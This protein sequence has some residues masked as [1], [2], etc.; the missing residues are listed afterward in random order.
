LKPLEIATKVKSLLFENTK[1]S[2]MKV[3][4]TIPR[5]GLKSEPW[6][7][8][9]C[10][11]KK[12]KLRS[13]ANKVNKTPNDAEVRNMLSE[14][15]RD[16]KRIIAIKK[17]QHKQKAVSEL[18]DKK[19]EG[20]PK[21]FWKLFRKISPK[22][23][24]NPIMPDISKFSEHFKKI[25]NSARPLNIPPVCNDAGPLDYIIT[26]E[27]LSEATD[28]LKLGKAFG[29]DI[30]CNEMIISLV[31]THPKI[32]LKLFNSTLSSNEVI[33]DWVIGMIVPLYKD[34]SKMDANNYR[35][36]TLISCLGKLFLS[37]LN[38]RLTVFATDNNLLTKSALGFV[39]GNRTSDAHIII[40]NLVNKVCHQDRSHIYSCFVDFKKAFD[41]V[42]RDILLKKLL[43]AG[44]SGKFFNIIRYIYTTDKACIKLGNTQSDFFQLS[45]G[46]RQGCILSPLLFN[47]FLSD[48][49]RKFESMEN[50]FQVG[51]I[52]INSLFWADDLVLFAK[53][54]EDLDNLLK[55][56]ETYC[57]EN[58]ITINT[59]KTKCMIFNKGGRLMRRQFY[60]DG[61]QLENVRSYKYLGFLITP[62]GE[63]NTGF[64]DLR[65]RALKAFMKIKN[66]MGMS[67]NQNLGTTLSLIDALIKPILLYCGDFWGCLKLPRNNHIE[68]MHMMICKRL[69]GVQK[70]TTNVGVLLEL[71]RIPLH[72]YASK[73]AVKN[74]ERIRLGIGNEILL[75][76]CRNSLDNFGWLHNIKRTLETNKMVDFYEDVP[77]SVYPFIHKKLFDK[78]KDKFHQ[79]SFDQI[80]LD[81]S[82]LRTYAI[83]KSEVG[84]EDYLYEIKNVTDRV[85]VTKFRLSNH[86]LMIEVGRHNN[87]PKELRYCPFCPNIVENE[88][89]FMFTC[90]SYTHLR[91][92]YLEPVCNSIP[93]FQYLPHDA[94]L[95][96]LLSS[97][98]KGTCKFIAS[99]MDLRRFLTSRPKNTD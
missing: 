45:L 10:K 42:P 94:K 64:K 93:S 95:Q 99:S 96:A 29:L 61:V 38:S 87:T 16:F 31:K 72:L 90:P 73:F 4:K 88:K 62:S 70:Q 27:E 80:K 74:W 78:L 56:L 40:H 6:F 22:S 39:S 65:D 77:D 17:R 5:E 49:A 30:I 84:I 9:E 7:D 19:Y 91:K 71:G 69:M 28:R 25:S 34:G 13:L 32:V 57:K 26:L 2:A 47:I 59:K 85:L 43:S 51:E 8:Q 46:V 79:T 82:K 86:R 54:K 35:G 83:F 21:E 1:I 92:R 98:E 48:L 12:E 66:D 67:F 53:N 58:E 33:P 11:V 81:S 68:N 36:I 60:L 76:S 20:T 3:K 63:I 41:S 75:E 18:E 50:G 14:T 37:I 55:T 23:Q 44:I 89:H 24:K 52:S 15:K 97:L